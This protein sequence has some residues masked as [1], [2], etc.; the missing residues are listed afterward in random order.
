MLELIVSENVYMA[1]RLFAEQQICC[2]IFK[3]AVGKIW[4]NNKI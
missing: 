2:Y 4:F 1:L 3:T